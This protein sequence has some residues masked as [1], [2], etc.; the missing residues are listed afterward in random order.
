MSFVRNNRIFVLLAFVTFVV[1]MGAVQS[2]CLRAQETTVL[3]KF[4]QSPAPD[5]KPLEGAFVLYD[6]NANSSLHHNEARCKQRYSPFATFYVPA[7]LIGLETGAIPDTSTI[8]N[9]ERKKYPPQGSWDKEWM[10]NQ[11]MK[12]ALKYSVAWYYREL[13]KRVG[14]RDVKNYLELFPYGNKDIA[15]GIYSKN[16]MEAFW[17][18]S[19]LAISADEQVTFLRS[20]Y[21]RTLPLGVTNINMVKDLLTLEETPRY[22]LCVSTGSGLERSTGK[23]LGWCIGLVE[24]TALTGEKNVYYFA[25]NLDGTSPT[26]VKSRPLQ[27]ARQCLRELGVLPK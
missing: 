11:A 12:T 14:E 27:I 1:W 7:S 24:T 22:R 17:F 19:S 25:L 10:D 20:M 26:H 8:I 18:G 9:W 15:G 3:A 21:T 23:Y 5:S 6:Q 4:F 2:L 13:I 16:V